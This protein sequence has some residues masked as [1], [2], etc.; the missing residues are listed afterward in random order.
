MLR[1]AVVALIF[2]IADS[3]PGLAVSAAVRS[4]CRDD[5]HR[6]CEP[7]IRDAAKRRACM[8]A[9]LGELSQKCVEALHKG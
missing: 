8:R 5:A 4:A 2:M 3:S 6:L 9:H 1:V 7:V